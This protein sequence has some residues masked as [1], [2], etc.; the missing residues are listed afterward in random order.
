MILGFAGKH[1]PDEVDKESV[2][3]LEIQE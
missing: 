3:E 1:A 2:K